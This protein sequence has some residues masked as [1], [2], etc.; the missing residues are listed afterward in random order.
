M[1]DAR[2]RQLQLYV[3]PSGRKPFNDWLEGGIQDP[4]ARSRLRTRLERVALGNFGQHRALCEGIVEL[5]IDTGPGY[6]IY[7]GIAGE[8]LVVLLCGGDKSSQSRDIER[9]RRYWKDFRSRH[10]KTIRFLS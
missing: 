5:K 3:D 2:E 8:T 6:R 10:E 1:S 4:V 7:L 9:A